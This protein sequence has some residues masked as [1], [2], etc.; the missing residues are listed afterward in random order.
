M[1]DSGAYLTAQTA[2]TLASRT[3]GVQPLNIIDHQN[4][5]ISMNI[6][7]NETLPSS[8]HYVTPWVTYTEILS[9][10]LDTGVEIDL[11]QLPIASVPPA[12]QRPISDHLV[13]LFN[14]LLAGT[15]SH[16]VL[17]GS[18]QAAS[19]FE[20]ALSAPPPAGSA[21][22]N[23]E[24]PIDLRLPTD[25]DFNQTF[26]VASPPQF[27]VAMA[28]SLTNW[29][30]SNNLSLKDRPDLWQRGNLRFDLSLFSSV[31]QSGRPILRLRRLIIP[32]S[33]IA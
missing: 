21:L 33:K 18:F 23:V 31:S 16:A 7:R 11:S 8:F 22:P 27:I 25:I 9:P 4:G 26:G 13:A 3:V 24:L 5:L 19:Y 15:D 1:G 2:I 32:C 17:S 12:A 28:Q 20:Y 6:V 10:V 29:L 14:L 30:T